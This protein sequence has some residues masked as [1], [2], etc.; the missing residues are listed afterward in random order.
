MKKYA[1]EFVGTGLFVFTII[2]IITSANIFAPIAIGVT[3]MSLIYIGA[4]ISGSHFNPAV[5]LG[6]LWSKKIKMNEAAPYIV[7]QVL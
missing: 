7:A 4:H 2:C 1:M 6:L 5:T 3:L